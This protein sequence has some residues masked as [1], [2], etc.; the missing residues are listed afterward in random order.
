M[1]PDDQGTFWCGSVTAR[2]VRII[3]PHFPNEPWFHAAVTVL[4]VRGIQSERA[5]LRR[6][7]EASAPPEG[8]AGAA[9]GTLV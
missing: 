2:T 9:H 1:A 5:S 7:A 6:P 3:G 8:S 4:S